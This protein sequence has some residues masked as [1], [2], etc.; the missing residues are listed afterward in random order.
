MKNTNLKK[1]FVALIASTL[2]A[3]FTVAIPSSA[4]A[5]ETCTKEYLTTVSGRV[6]FTKCV[7]TDGN[8]SKYE[9]RMPAK[10]NGTLFTYAHGIRYGVALP[11]NPAAGTPAVPINYEPEV[12]P[13]EAV[14]QSMLAA[15]Y[16]LAGSGATS[17]GWNLT[18]LTDA[19]L[20]VLQIARDKYSKISKVVAWGNSLG[21][22]TTQALS[23]Q[24]SGAIDAALPMCIADSAQA[25]ITMAGDFLWGLKVLFNPAIKGTGY[26]AGQ[27]G[28]IEMLGDLAQV[29]ATL[30]E[31]RTA[32]IADPL[33]PKWPTTSTAPAN[34]QAIPVRA[35]VMLLG[36][37][38]GI[39]TQS[40]TY[41]GVAGPPGASET[42]FGAALSP[43]LAVL[44]NG[45]EAAG[46][47]VLAN[48][49]MERRASGVVFDNSTTNYST[50]LGTA[51][52]TYA[53]AL[54]GLDAARGILLYLSAMPRVKSDPAAV[55]TLN[56]IYQIQGK[57]EVPTIALSATSDHI[58][59]AGAAQ[60]LIDQ[61]NDAIDNGKAKAGKLVVIWNKPPNEYTKF[62]ASGAITPTVPT[63][64]VGHCTF[65]TAQVM[66]VAK[67]AAT[68]A[69]TGKIPSSTAVKAAIKSDENL[70]VNPNY[71]PDLLKFRQ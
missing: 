53:A 40:N 12:A 59:P 57:I 11:A 15:G 21:G 38:S 66:T 42:T 61:Y 10:F 58:T 63:N 36:L 19:T 37:V 6:D 65:T 23:E 33:K 9:I 18:E 39:S 2:V 24:F 8:G 41:D 16:A 35:A 4:S 62:G 46:L 60:Y 22:L 56:S 1:G 70:F 54:S 17:Q 26:S 50:R 48:Y 13:T 55:A 52:T 30:T 51:G 3:V 67:M 44:E 49:D 28:Y 7:G 31:I 43:A 29:R 45:A 5:A 34:L 20:Q 25:E 64:G 69:K 71:K 14:A 68:A 47:A 32:I 27:T